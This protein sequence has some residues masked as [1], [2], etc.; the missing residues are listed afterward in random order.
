[1]ANPMVTSVSPA[2]GP[3]SGGTEVTIVGSGFT[4]ATAV[5]F[6]GAN[7]SSFSV[8]SDTQITAVTPPGLGVVDVDVVVPAPNQFVYVPTPSRVEITAVNPALGSAGG[9]DVVSITGHGFTGAAGVRFGGNDAM[10]IS[11]DSDT[12]ITCTSPP[13]SGTVDIT[14]VTPAGTS[15]A[16]PADQFTYE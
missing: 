6:G 3:G 1:M 12:Q 14:V 7:A 8:D 15:P 2:T 16:T 4:G 10:A 5:A 13:G 9:G 11:A